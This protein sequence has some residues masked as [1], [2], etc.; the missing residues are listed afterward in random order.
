MWCYNCGGVRGGEVGEDP[1]IH[2]MQNIQLRVYLDS[3]ELNCSYLPC[4]TA[5]NEIVSLA[6]EDK[7]NCNCKIE[8][9][10]RYICII[11]EGK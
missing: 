5:E 8:I 4:L 9:I 6:E 7:T 3:L 10:S 2:F 11:G 1:S